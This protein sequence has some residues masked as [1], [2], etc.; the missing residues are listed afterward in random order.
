MV[1]QGY[2][3]SGGKRIDLTLKLE[4]IHHCSQPIV[5]TNPDSGRKSLYVATLNTMWIEGMDRAESEAILQRLFDIVEDPSII[6]DHV[7]QIGDLVMW[8]NL[9]CLH[10]RTNWPSEQRR[11]LRRCTVEGKPLY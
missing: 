11:T 2:Q 3:Y 6:Y 4:D 1:M 8:D 9:A 7:W 10:A 5:I